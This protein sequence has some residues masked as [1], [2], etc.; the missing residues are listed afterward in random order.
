MIGVR[1]CR[2]FVAEVIWQVGFTPGTILGHAIERP[3]RRLIHHRFVATVKA[4][5]DAQDQRTFHLA[6]ALLPEFFLCLRFILYHGWR[7]LPELQERINDLQNR[8]N[9]CACGWVGWVQNRC[10]IQ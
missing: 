6:S 3:P 4:I 2:P 1:S 9:C 10:A 8:D 5:L 7:T